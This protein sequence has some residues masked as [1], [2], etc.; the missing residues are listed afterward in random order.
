MIKNMA[1]P[2]E[3]RLT[4][5]QNSFFSKA[6]VVDGSHSCTYLHVIFNAV[7]HLGSG[8]ALC[9]NRRD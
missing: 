8:F 1:K 3:I 7:K 9:K 2:K 5:M 6:K 4:S